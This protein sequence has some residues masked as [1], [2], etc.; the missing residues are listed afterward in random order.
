MRDEVRSAPDNAR[1]IARAAGAENRRLM[2]LSLP[3]LL[4]IGLVIVLPGL[5][6]ASF[7]VWGRGGFTLANYAQI[8]DASYAQSMLV[9]LQLA[10]FVT[11]L[12]ALLGYPFCYMLLLASPR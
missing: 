3:A 5:W 6:L 1:E 12:C 9:T 2:A 10:V 8:F 4:V 11:V 7:S